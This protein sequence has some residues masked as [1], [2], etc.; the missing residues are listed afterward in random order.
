MQKADALT[1][2]LSIAQ[3]ELRE[4]KNE[5]AALPPNDAMR[6]LRELE[7]VEARSKALAR[8]TRRMRGH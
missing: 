7:L 2:L 3:Q 6:L 8:E 4:L 5:A 1:L